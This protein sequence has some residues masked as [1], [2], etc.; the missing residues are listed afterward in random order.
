MA[1]D[2]G[3]QILTIRGSGDRKSKWSCTSSS[4]LLHLVLSLRDE[5]AKET[6]GKKL[7]VSGIES[8]SV[9]SRRRS[10]DDDDDKAEDDAAANAAPNDKEDE[11]H[12]A[13]SGDIAMTRM[14]EDNL[15]QE[16]HS[17]FRRL[18][19]HSSQA[20]RRRSILNDFLTREN[21]VCSAGR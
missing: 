8:S 9:I 21:R 3:L 20:S 6:G 1:K 15:R 16:S 7:A 18:D 14:E 13:A 2:D 17:R 4:D 11:A 10:D 19:G 12:G 5:Y